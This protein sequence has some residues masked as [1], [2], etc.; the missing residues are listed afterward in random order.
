MASLAVT[1]NRI[2]KGTAGALFAPLFF[3]VFFARFL[4]LSN[5]KKKGHSQVSEEKMTKI[6]DYFFWVI[7]LQKREI[8]AYFLFV[9]SNF[10][11]FQ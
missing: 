4:V 8:F 2:L 10:L 3:A 9:L 1:R 6:S 7:F 11:C 5:S